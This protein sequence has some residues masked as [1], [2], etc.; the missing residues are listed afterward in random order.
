MGVMHTLNRRGDREVHWDLA[1]PKSVEKAEKEFNRYM[2]KGGL[3]FVPNGCEGE[4]IK[5]FKP[6][7]ERIIITSQLAGGR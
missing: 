1:D 3:A 5:T 4:Q 2:E 6:E 7:A